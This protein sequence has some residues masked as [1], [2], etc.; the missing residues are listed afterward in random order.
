M[1]V[2]V[3]ILD[4]DGPGARCELMR[5]AGKGERAFTRELHPH[6]VFVLGDVNAADAGVAARLR[7]QG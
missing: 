5:L 2:A 6:H 7:G 1:L 3:D 4:V